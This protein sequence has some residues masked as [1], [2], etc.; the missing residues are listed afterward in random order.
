MS[1]EKMLKALKNIV[2]RIEK[3]NCH[4]DTID[5]HSILEPAPPDSGW[6]CFKDTGKRV[7][8][9]HYSKV[10]ATTTQEQK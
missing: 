1:Q 4:I 9:V 10:S 7:L 5:H 2:D 3:N 8:T 6:A